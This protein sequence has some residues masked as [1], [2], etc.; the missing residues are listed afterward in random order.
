MKAKRFVQAMFSV[1]RQDSTHR[2]PG[3]SGQT[4]DSLVFLAAVEECQDFQSLERPRIRMIVAQ[5][6][7]SSLIIFGETNVTHPCFACLRALADSIVLNPELGTKSKIARELV[8]VAVF[9]KSDIEKKAQQQKA[10]PL[11]QM[12]SSCPASRRVHP[13]F[14]P[15]LL[16]KSRSVAKF[17]Y[18]AAWTS[19][20]NTFKNVSLPTAC[21]IRHIYANHATCRVI[22]HR[23]AAAYSLSMKR[24]DIQQI[25]K[26]VEKLLGDKEALPGHVEA[27]VDRLLNLVESLCKD[28]DGLKCEADRL[29][30]LLEEKKRNKPGGA[31]CPKR[32]Y[33]S[34]KRRTPGKPSP[35]HP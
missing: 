34:D 6:S 19:N 35:P 3:A 13:L 17:F 28:I 29:R 2:G 31:D 30:K 4:G 15:E 11:V 1:S 5:F 22:G 33:S 32:D 10:E 26:E 20:R 9:E 27:A 21:G 24:D 18:P 25:L 16:L 12:N 8:Q 23:C 7:N 14:V